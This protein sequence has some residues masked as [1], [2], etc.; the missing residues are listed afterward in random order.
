MVPQ[1][2]VG[3][4]QWVVTQLLLDRE[5]DKNKLIADKENVITTENPCILWKLKWVNKCMLTP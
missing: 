1:L 5:G 2:W 4:L 3:T